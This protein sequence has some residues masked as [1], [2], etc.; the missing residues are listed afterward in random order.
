MHGRCPVLATLSAFP[1]QL[2]VQPVGKIYSV[3]SEVWE[4]N[5]PPLLLLHLRQL[6]WGWR[7]PVCTT[8]QT[9]RML[10]VVEQ[11]NTQKGRLTPQNFLTSLEQLRRGQEF[12]KESDIISLKG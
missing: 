6:L 10:S 2:P 4:A 1:S 5:T 3:V 11:S 7:G 12:Q 9:P 8:D